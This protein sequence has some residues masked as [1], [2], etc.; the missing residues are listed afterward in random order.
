MDY[1]KAIKE[2]IGAAETTVKQCL[3]DPKTTLGKGLKN[4]GEEG[5]L[6]TALE[7]GISNLYGYNSDSGAVRHGLKPDESLSF[8]YSEAKFLVSIYANLVNYLIE[9]YNLS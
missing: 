5:N 7:K 6:H 1:S 3:N 9:K 4:I 8:D 2:S